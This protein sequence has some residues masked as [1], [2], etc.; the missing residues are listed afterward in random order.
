MRRGQRPASR[1]TPRETEIVR[2]IAEG[3]SNKQIALRLSIEFATVKNHV[4][5]ILEK[6]E[7]DRRAE[8]AA[9]VASDVALTPALRD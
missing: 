2:L 1:L 5:R 7:V 9:R 6:L 3:L 8:A 4:H